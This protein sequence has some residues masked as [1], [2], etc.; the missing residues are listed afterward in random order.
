MPADTTRLFVALRPDEP[1]DALIR[2]HKRR[3]LAAAGPQL[4]ATDPPHTT[5]YLAEFATGRVAD[6]IRAAGELAGTIPMPTVAIDGWHVFQSDPLTGLHTLACRFD[7]ASCER[8]RWVQLHLVAALAP[9][10]DVA[11]TQQAL[12][13]RWPALSGEQRRRGML[14]GFPYLGRGW[15]PHLTIAS[16]RPSEW[17]NV[18]QV[19]NLSGNSPGQVASLSYFTTLDVFELHGLEPRLLATFALAGR[20]LGKVA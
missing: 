14:F 9:L 12:V 6:V 18:G 19:F 1:L 11:A 7:E 15:I 5:L 17:K 13:P 10:H 20:T 4:Y 2:G 3:L 8:L 16:V